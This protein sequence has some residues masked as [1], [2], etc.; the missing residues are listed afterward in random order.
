MTRAVMMRVFFRRTAKFMKPRAWRKFAHRIGL[1]IHTSGTFWTWAYSMSEVRTI[2]RN[3]R[4]KNTAP[5]ARIIEHQ[6]EARLG[7]GAE[8]QPLPPGRRRRRG[9]V[10]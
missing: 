7:A 2:Q 4:A 9:R 8:A 3:G 10:L 6:L 1:G 5:A